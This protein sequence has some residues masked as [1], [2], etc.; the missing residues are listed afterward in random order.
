MNFAVGKPGPRVT[1]DDIG[2]PSSRKSVTGRIDG[3]HIADGMLID[4]G[5]EEMVP[6][7]RLCI[8]D[9]D[10]SELDLFFGS[11]RP[12][13]LVSVWYAVHPELRHWL[14]RLEPAGG[15]RWVFRME[16]FHLDWLRELQ[17]D[18]PDVFGGEFQDGASGI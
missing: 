4:F 11:V 5:N 14:G 7:D 17:R 9:G 16:P 2:L 6:G 12:D 8:R 1:N 13:G 10:G 3:R 18:Y 15:S